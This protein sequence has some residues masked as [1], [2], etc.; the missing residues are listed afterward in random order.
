MRIGVTLCLII[1]NVCLFG[2]IA[3]LQHSKALNAANFAPGIGLDTASFSALERIELIGPSLPSARILKK[4][5]RKWNLVSPIEWPANPFA[6]Q[7]ILTQLEFL[8][9]DISFPVSEVLESGQTLADYG[10]EAPILSINLATQTDSWTI[11]IGETS[12]T[13]S[14]I[15]LLSPDKAHILVAS[16]TLLTSLLLELDDLRNPQLFTIPPFEIQGLTLQLA[17]PSGAKVRLAKTGEHWTFEAPFQTE[18]DDYAVNALV[19]ALSALPITRFIEGD[20]SNSTL[21]GLDEPSLRLTLEGFH[22]R[23]TLLV[24]NR[25]NQFGMPPQV[26]ASLEGAKAILVLPAT[27]IDTLQSAQETLRQR[28]FLSFDPAALNTLTI[29]Q[30]GHSVLLEHLETGLWQLKDEATHTPL[31]ADEPVIETLLEFL[32]NLEALYFVSDAPSAADLER[33]SLQD[34][35]RIIELKG[36]ETITLMI[37]GLDTERGLLYAKLANSPCVYGVALNILDQTPVRPLYYR[38]RWLDFI[39]KTLPLQSLT[40]TD[41]ETQKTLLN[42]TFSPSGTTENEWGDFL[43]TLPTQQA[44][45]AE[46]LLKGVKSMRV[47]EFLEEPFSNTPTLGK[48][49]VLSWKYRLEAQHLEKTATADTLTPGNPAQMLITERL[50]GQLQLAGTPASGLTFTLP[51]NWVDAIED[52]ARP[53]K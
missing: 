18:A 35:Q 45:A 41:L 24:G 7:R 34:P 47:R 12:T 22:R 37:G 25:I 5:N 4:E 28:H 2:L 53:L 27:V 48:D 19:S 52:L 16:R 40:L 9:R 11:A 23:E 31:S 8:E 51:Q 43:K 32:L 6:V 10:L 30:S 33:W 14:R 17:R 39:P 21:T 20:T 38:S 49:E 26:Y 15:Y 13:D 50:D 36:P 42:Y 46:T 29:S 3:F 44:I 1:A